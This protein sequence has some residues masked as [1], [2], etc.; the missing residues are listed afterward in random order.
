MASEV[1]KRLR[2]R[3]RSVW[4]ECKTLAEDAANENRSF[5]AEEQ[6]KWEVMNEEMDTLDKRIKSALE[7]EKRAAEAD[8]TYN[9][10]T[11]RE[12][13]PEAEVR[14]GNAELNTE[15]RQFLRGESRQRSLEIAQPASSRVNWNYGPI[16]LRTLSTSTTGA[17][18]NLVPTDFYD[19]LIAHLIQ[20]SGILQAGPTVINTAGGETLQIPKTTGHSLA[21]S[22][23]QAG[24]IPS[25]DPAFGLATLSAYKYGVLL[26][27]A[28]E[29]LDDSGVD[30]VGY[31]AMQAGR[32][33]GNKFGSDLVTGA[34]TTQPSGVLTGASS[35]V[36][37]VSST[38]GASYTNLVNLE[39]SVIAPYRASRSCYWMAAD[40][41][42]GQFRLIVDNNGR[43]VW[44]PSM[45]L[46]SPD[47]LLG[48]PLVADPFMPVTGATGQKIV[49][50]GDFS[51]FFVRIVGPVRFE[52]S[53]DYLFGSDLVAFRALIRGDGVLVDQ[54][55]AI[56]YATT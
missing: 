41:T 34:G 38:T 33:L 52:R 31:L 8:A 26:Q 24:A 44:E 17:G 25:S 36:T 4:E 23:A 12:R 18:G 46:G 37:G 53:D 35:G 47:L 42:I 11:S 43:P 30:L 7:A 27:V 1:T 9:E 2:D 3:R 51:Q 29:L 32:A 14:G 10:I 56:K 5:S 40:S 28:R 55:G 20:V 22:A 6:G 15:I 19:Q 49:L 50:F 21:A 13:K 54:T 39:Y 45:V 16:D 48:K